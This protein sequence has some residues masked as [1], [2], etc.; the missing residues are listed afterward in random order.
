M[1]F[2]ADN[3]I[4]LPFEETACKLSQFYPLENQGWSWRTKTL[5]ESDWIRWELPAEIKGMYWAL[6]GLCTTRKEL[7]ENSE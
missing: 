5:G 4:T 1:T 6:N 7:L 3:S 2:S